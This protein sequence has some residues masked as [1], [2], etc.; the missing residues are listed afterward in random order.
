MS[1]SWA[2]SAFRNNCA[3]GVT[4]CNSN[5]GCYQDGAT[6]PTAHT[7]EHWHGA[8]HATPGPLDEKPAHPDVAPTPKLLLGLH[9]PL[10]QERCLSGCQGM[11]WPDR[12]PSSSSAPTPLR[13]HAPGTPDAKPLRLPQQKDDRTEAEETVYLPVLQSSLHQKLQ[14]AHTRENP[15]RRATLLLRH[16]RQG[17][18]KTGPPSRPQVII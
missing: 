16:L 12:T 14:P 6:H 10:A 9:R 15:H 2:L 7:S 3:S 8:T 4:K 5:D 13:P 17:L 11:L 18:Q 1:A